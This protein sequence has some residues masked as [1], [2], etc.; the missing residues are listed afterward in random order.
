MSSGQGTSMEYYPD[1]WAKRGRILAP[2]FRREC[3]RTSFWQTASDN[4]NGPSRKWYRLIQTSWSPYD[5]Y[6]T[7]TKWL[8]VVITQH[9]WPIA[10][11]V[12]SL[13]RAVNK[14][15]H[16]TRTLSQM[17]SAD[18]VGTQICICTNHISQRRSGRHPT[19]YST[20]KNTQIGICPRDHLYVR[21]HNTV[22]D[23]T[24][25]NNP[26]VDSTIENNH[27]CMRHPW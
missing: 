4:V 16:Q 17:I 5:I 23:A 12:D 15:H 24:K 3:G 10:F 6:T 19:E 14:H 25:I 21:I 9:N 13:Q 20:V 7:S 11:L 27:A 8:G 22:A 18:V 1:M 26:K 2:L